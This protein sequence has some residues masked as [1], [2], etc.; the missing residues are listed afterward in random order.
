VFNAIMGGNATFKQAFAVVVH[1]QWL[2]ALA[3]LFMYPIDY[4]KQSLSSPTN[5]AVFMPF[6]DEGSFLA[7]LLGSIDLF[8][9]WWIVNLAIGIGVLY[10]RRTS[11]IATTLLVIYAV[12]ALCIAA[13][14]V[15]FSG[16]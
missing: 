10:K 3:T 6:L 13:I 8:R 14:G 15:A 1:A 12:I 4:A 11:P 9:I 5:L 2:S 16:A 7:R